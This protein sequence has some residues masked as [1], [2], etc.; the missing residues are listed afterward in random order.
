MDYALASVLSQQSSLL[1][2]I[3]LYDIA[4]QYWINLIK[5]FTTSFSQQVPT[6]TRLRYGVGKMH[7]QGHKDNCMYRFSLNY[8][9]CC[10]RTPGEMVETCW[11]EGNQTGASTREMNAGH[12]HDMLDDFHGDWNWRKVQKM[13]THA[14][15]I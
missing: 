13:C 14:S 1:W 9:Q 4:C 6:A 11:V 3:F 12:R 2:I 7:I 15:H 5:R 10:R 8:M